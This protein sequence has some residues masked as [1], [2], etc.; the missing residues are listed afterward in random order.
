MVRQCDMKCFLVSCGK[1]T[2]HGLCGA[3]VAMFGL[4]LV[5]AMQSDPISLKDPEPNRR[6]DS[7]GTAQG[8]EEA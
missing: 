4:D 3:A 5:I 2:Q 8:A 6:E 7:P 1:E